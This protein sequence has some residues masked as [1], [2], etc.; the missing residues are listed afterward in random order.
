MIELKEY[1]G[2]IRN[3]ESLCEELNIAKNLTREEREQ[4]I[5]VKAYSAWGKNVADHLY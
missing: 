2:H 3:W 5:L 4:Q 1:R